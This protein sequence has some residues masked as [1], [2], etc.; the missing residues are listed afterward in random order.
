MHSERLRLRT[1]LQATLGAQIGTSDA[2]PRLKRQARMRRRQNAAIPSQ[3][4]I[5]L[6]LKGK[7]IAEKV[8]VTRFSGTLMRASISTSAAMLSLQ[9]PSTE[10]LLSRIPVLSNRATFEL[11]EALGQVR[12]R[13]EVRWIEWGGTDAIRLAKWD[14]MGHL[15]QYRHDG[16]ASCGHPISSRPITLSWSTSLQVNS[17][18][19]T[20]IAV[21]SPSSTVPTPVNAAEAARH[22]S[23]SIV[24]VGSDGR[25]FAGWDMV[26]SVWHVGLG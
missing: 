1:I 10:V 18:Q 5:Q 22:L 8:T 6:L 23:T 24:E 21:V 12:Y 3:M 26:A 19:R 16:V 14:V 4:R 13:S 2:R 25:A 17:S 15:G 7:I 9:P 11:Q 20:V